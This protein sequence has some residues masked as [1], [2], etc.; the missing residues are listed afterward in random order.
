MSQT[1]IRVHVS[2]DVQSIDRSIAFYDK[3]FGE[4][5]SKVRPAYANFRLDS[6]PVHLAL[7]EGRHS[8]GGGV[9][10]LGF[11][12]PDHEQLAKWQSRFEA[13]GIDF[14]PE[15]EAKCCYAKSDKLWV[16]DPDGYRW[17]VWVR[18]GEHEAMGQTRAEVNQSTAPCC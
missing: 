5:P 2:L 13:S 18:T 15:N 9:S 10:H 1:N 11:E 6:P 14:A 8:S 3:L 7:Q 12:L 4:R 17:E 16:T